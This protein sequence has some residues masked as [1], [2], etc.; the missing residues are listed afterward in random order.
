[1]Q[2][3]TL[4]YFLSESGILQFPTWYLNLHILEPIYDNLDNYVAMLKSTR[5]LDEL[6]REKVKDSIK[7]YLELF[8]QL[9][10]KKSAMEIFQEWIDSIKVYCFQ[11]GYGY[12]ISYPGAPHHW[13]I[14]P[15]YY[16][17]VAKIPEKVKLAACVSNQ[18]IDISERAE[19]ERW[20]G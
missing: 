13:V 18:Y 4:D 9:T 3:E 14:K 7:E 5:W 15:E 20:S 10:Y 19:W 8:I 17:Q 16:E 12:A 1:M 2:L 11:G 6:S